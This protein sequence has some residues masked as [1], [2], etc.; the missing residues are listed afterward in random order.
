[1]AKLVIFAHQ[2]FSVTPSRGRIVATVYAK[3]VEWNIATVTLANASVARTWLESNATVARTI[4]MVMIRATVVKRV[5]V[6]SPLKV[7]SAMT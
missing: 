5:I 1:M 3:N 6:E 4:T 7:V 2:D